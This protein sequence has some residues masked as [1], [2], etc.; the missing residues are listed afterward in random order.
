MKHP[1]DRLYNVVIIGAG[2]AG[3]AAANK[4]GEL[5]VPVTLVDSEPDLDSKLS[6]EEHRLKGDA[7]PGV[8]E[9]ETESKRPGLSENH[10]SMFAAPRKPN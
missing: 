1:N 9:P 4:L 5:G 7:M 10:A 3:L 2:P 6:V 8:P